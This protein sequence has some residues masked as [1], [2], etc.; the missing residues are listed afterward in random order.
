M[1]GWQL[2]GLSTAGVCRLDHYPQ[3]GECPSRPC[4]QEWPQTQAW[5]LAL[6]ERAGWLTLSPTME[7]SKLAGASRKGSA[8]DCAIV[9]AGAR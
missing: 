6:E 3:K 5:G 7:P 8:F 1:L 9:G 4:G 2:T